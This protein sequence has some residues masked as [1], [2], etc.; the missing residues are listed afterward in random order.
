MEVSVGHWLD[1]TSILHVVVSY[2]TVHDV[3]LEFRQTIMSPFA[4]YP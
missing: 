4:S 3:D 2:S 1:R